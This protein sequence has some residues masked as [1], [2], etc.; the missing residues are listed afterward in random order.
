MER[1]KPIIVPTFDVVTAGSF[2]CGSR[3]AVPTPSPVKSSG[4]TLIWVIQ[5]CFAPGPMYMLK[6]GPS[7]SGNHRAIARWA[8]LWGC[9][10]LYLL[11]R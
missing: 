8:C 5:S 10:Q 3:V 2:Y 1:A 4:P 6:L 11:S 9:A 7:V